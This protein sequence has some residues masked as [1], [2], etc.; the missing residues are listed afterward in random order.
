MANHITVAIARLLAYQLFLAG[1]S[2]ND[3]TIKAITLLETQGHENQGGVARA[4]LASF[5]NLPEIEVISA[6]LR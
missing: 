1:L 5:S 2:F 6:K 3:K 4:V